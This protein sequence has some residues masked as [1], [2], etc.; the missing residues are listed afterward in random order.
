MKED[1]R[2]PF[3]VLPSMD[4]WRFCRAGALKRANHM[5]FRSGEAEVIVCL[6]ITPEFRT[7]SEIFT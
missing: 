5:L 7:R 1:I 6:K 4:A 2:G 3:V